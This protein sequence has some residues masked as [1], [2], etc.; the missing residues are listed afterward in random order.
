MQGLVVE[1]N[2]NKVR[3]NTRTWVVNR[4]NT[5]V[6]QSQ[7][8]DIH[9]ERKVSCRAHK[10]PYYVADKTKILKLNLDRQYKRVV[11]Y[12]RELGIYLNESDAPSQMETLA[13]LMYMG[14][15]AAVKKLLLRD[16]KKKGYIYKYISNPFLLYLDGYIDFYSAQAIS[17]RTLLP[18][19]PEE[20]I[21]AYLYY[22]L[23]TAYKNNMESLR[24]SDAVYE[25][26]SLFEIDEDIVWKLLEEIKDSKNKQKGRKRVHVNDRVY[27]AWIYYMKM[28]VLKMLERNMP[29]VPENV[30]DDAICTLL[31][32]RYTVLTGGPGTGKT[33]LLRRI[34]E[35][36]NA[37]NGRCIFSALTGKA[38]QVLGNNAV[39]IHSLLGYGPKGFLKKQLDCDLLV[40]DEASMLN[41]QTLHAIVTAAPRVIFA[42]DPEQLPPVEG[43]NV[44]A[45][46]LEMLPT[47]RLEQQWR[48]KNGL[49]V[50][51]VRRPS[52][53]A[54]LIELTKILSTLKGGDSQVITPIHSGL[55]GTAYLNRYLQKICNG[56][57]EKVGSEKECIEKDYGDKV[58]NDKDSGEK[59]MEGIRKGD[60]VIVLK[61]IYRNKYIKENNIYS[62]TRK[63]V[64]ANGM[65]GTVEE[66][67]YLGGRP[68]YLVYSPTRGH[69]LLERNDF[70]LAYALTVHK[71]QGSESDY[72]VFVLPDRKKIREDFITDEM[73]TV[74]KT[75]GRV[76][77]YVLEVSEDVEVSEGVLE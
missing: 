7:A 20:K 53:K 70:D 17:L 60:R 31:S 43:E 75:R 66:M 36:F 47:V 52:E 28:R 27:I 32:H 23:D 2:N 14:R 13:L 25:I 3:L 40:V 1:H 58:C 10:V 63:L 11:R 74:G 26:S 48:Y 9:G 15:R 6:G 71:F 4:T 65:I 59:V 29:I 76:K 16:T 12:A 33:T 22:V 67:R 39:T 73:L 68:F 45:A 8:V 46:I 24:L 62:S 44:F 41:W 50:E 35:I 42:G 72:V 51:V 5:H 55:L 69:V 34:G 38:A 64:A 61:N 56:T 37:R 21:Q 30:D 19:N 77:T 57:G 18:G 54:V 49:D